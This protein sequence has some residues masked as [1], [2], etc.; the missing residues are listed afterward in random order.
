MMDLFRFRRES[1]AKAD[2]SHR[3]DLGLSPS[4]GA[5]RDHR[6]RRRSLASHH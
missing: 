4:G 3:P 5:G 1:G 2:I 6:E